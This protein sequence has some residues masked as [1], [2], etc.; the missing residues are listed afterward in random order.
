MQRR[1]QL[2]LE[3]LNIEVFRELFRKRK[4]SCIIILFLAIFINCFQI[5]F[6]VIG[7]VPHHQNDSFLFVLTQKSEGPTQDLRYF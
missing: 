5:R 7:E 6:Q 3:R 4:T 2:R 1:L